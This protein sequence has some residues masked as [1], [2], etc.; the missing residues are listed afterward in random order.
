ME[1]RLATGKN[2]SR[3]ADDE[4][5]TLVQVREVAVEREGSGWFGIHCGDCTDSVVTDYWT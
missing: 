1:N 5:M 2:E 3:K 4:A